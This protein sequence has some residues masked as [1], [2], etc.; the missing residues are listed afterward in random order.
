MQCIDIPMMYMYMCVYVCICVFIICVYVCARVCVCVYVRACAYV[1][2][3]VRTYVCMYVCIHIVS[4]THKNTSPWTGS[5]VKANIGPLYFMRRAWFWRR[6]PC[7]TE[8][9]FVTHRGGQRAYTLCIMMTSS[10]G[11]IF[12]VTGSLCG[13]F[14]GHGELPSQRPVT[15]SFGVFFDLRLNKR[16]SKKWRD[17]LFETTSRSLWRHCNL[18]CMFIYG[19]LL[20]IHMYIYPVATDIK[21]VYY[22][23]ILQ[24][25][26]LDILCNISLHFNRSR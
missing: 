21:W 25:F 16:L 18:L 14:T 4:G 6:V 19:Y 9:P 5:R 3:Y 23:D 8:T 17:W 22:L 11:N 15:P 7:I 12:R 1:R 24:L 10:N 2:T 13:E 26:Y 20:Y